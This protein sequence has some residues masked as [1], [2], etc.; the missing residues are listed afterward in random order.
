MASGTREG[1][2]TLFREYNETLIRFLTRRLGNEADAADV[3]QIT[4]TKLLGIS[5]PSVIA[6]PRSYMFRVA[7]NS[8]TD[9]MR[10]RKRQHTQIGEL[11]RHQQ[12]TL[13]PVPSA[14]ER[15][16]EA[17]LEAKQRLEVIRE[18][19]QD[20]SP[21]CRWA[22]IEHRFSRKTYA[23]IA[24]ELGV[25]QNMVERYIIDAMAQIRRRLKITS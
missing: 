21:K 18:A 8:A 15:E 1:W 10:Q 4:F 11:S 24:R 23:E 14:L 6:N 12:T 16:A 22:F 2:S 19:L 7:V 17:E 25:S 13:Q 9:F 20:L 3:A 5:N